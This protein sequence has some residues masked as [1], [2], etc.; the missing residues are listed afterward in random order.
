[1]KVRL[2]VSNKDW[3]LKPNMFADVR[4][5]TDPQRGVLKIPR[6]AL[7]VT[8]KR[9]SVIVARGDGRFQPV[10]VVTGMRNDD[11]VEILSGLKE[12]EQVVVSGQFLIDSEANLRASF[13]RF[14]AEN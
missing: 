3:Q 5:F 8:G 11:E 10:D 6:E 14:G 13:A 4:I 1:M 2:L 9:Q 12:G 7:I